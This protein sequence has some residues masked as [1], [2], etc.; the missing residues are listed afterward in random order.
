VDDGHVGGND[1]VF[2]DT[3]LSVKSLDSGGHIE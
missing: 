1:N 3:V 2:V